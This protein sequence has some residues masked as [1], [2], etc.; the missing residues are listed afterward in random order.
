MQH[1]IIELILTESET[2]PD[3]MLS[4]TVKFNQIFKFLI[5]SH[6]YN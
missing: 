4:V 1:L 6:T 2:G 5:P 3:K